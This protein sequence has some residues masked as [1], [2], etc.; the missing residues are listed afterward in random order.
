MQNLPVSIKLLINKI[1]NECDNINQ[2]RN[3]IEK[4]NNNIK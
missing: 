1:Y 4:K 3:L 2:I